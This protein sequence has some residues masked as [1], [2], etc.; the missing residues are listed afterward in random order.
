M[1]YKGLEK[2][3]NLYGFEAKFESFGIVMFTTCGPFPKNDHNFIN[4]VNNMFN[5][6]L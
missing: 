3:L 2:L 5:R 6:M 1:N 4:I